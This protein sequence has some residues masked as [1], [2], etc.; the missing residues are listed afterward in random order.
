MVNV[1]C[2][3]HVAFCFNPQFVL[4]FLISQVS[5]PFSKLA[6][7][8]LLSSSYPVQLSGTSLSHT[9][10]LYCATL[11]HQDYAVLKTVARQG[12]ISYPN[13]HFCE[14]SRLIT[15]KSPILV[16]PNLHLPLLHQDPSHLAWQ[17]MAPDKHNC[18]EYQTL[19]PT[20][21]CSALAISLDCCSYY[22]A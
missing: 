3:E 11:C 22:T 2:F 12:Q 9:R 17:V 6:P 4:V 13:P 7:P 16:R 10:L 19:S 15:F 20:T 1:A 18:I 8:D 14:N 21:T 5:I